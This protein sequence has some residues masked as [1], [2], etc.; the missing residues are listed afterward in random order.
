[1]PDEGR[2]GPVS[3]APGGPQVHE[4]TTKRPHALSTRSVEVGFRA[5][6]RPPRGIAH[7]LRRNELSALSIAARL[8]RG[9]PSKVI[10]ERP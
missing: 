5:A 7:A 1:M 9:V 3:R 6:I 10:S 4:G 8:R 2:S